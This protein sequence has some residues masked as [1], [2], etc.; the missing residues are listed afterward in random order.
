MPLRGIDLYLNSFADQIFF[1]PP[2]KWFIKLSYN[3]SEMKILLLRLH[4]IWCTVI[5]FMIQQ[6]MPFSKVLSRD[7]I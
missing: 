2:I 3:K 5:L 1:S 4:Q 6:G 7:L